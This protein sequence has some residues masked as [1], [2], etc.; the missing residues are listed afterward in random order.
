MLSI[1][2]LSILSKPM[3][4]ADEIVNNEK[5]VVLLLKVI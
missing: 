2:K 4:A 3:E 5:Q 1:I